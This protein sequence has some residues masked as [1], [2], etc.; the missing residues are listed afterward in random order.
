[1]QGSNSAN[2][3]VLEELVEGI[4]VPKKEKVSNEG[5]MIEIRSVNM[6]QY[7]DALE[8]PLASSPA[9][10][11]DQRSTKTK[12]RK[13]PPSDSSS[14]DDS[15]PSSSEDDDKYKRRKKGKK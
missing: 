8:G 3:K 10:K 11:D 5:P 9:K 4:K 13:P 1:M 6:S 12:S 14:S 7:Y 2:K 15:P